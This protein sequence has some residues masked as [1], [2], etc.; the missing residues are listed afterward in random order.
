MEHSLG[1]QFAHNLNSMHIFNHEESAR[2]QPASGQQ[3]LVD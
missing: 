3:R 1:M 2:V